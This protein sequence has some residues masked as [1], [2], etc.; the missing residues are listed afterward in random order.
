MYVI[1]A[2]FGRFTTLI[3]L[4][5]NLSGLGLL[6]RLDRIIFLVLLLRNDSFSNFYFRSLLLID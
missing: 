5:L 1:E 2:T 3:L 4:H 6:F